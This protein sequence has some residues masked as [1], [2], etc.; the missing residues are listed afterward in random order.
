MGQKVHPT[1]FRIGITENWRSRWYSKKKEF[2]RLL[3][4]DQRV[5][6]FIKR[7]YEYAGIPK[8]EIERDFDFV[9]V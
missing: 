6:Q 5:R 4:E 3:V 1:G 9:K 8:I 2:G 7:E